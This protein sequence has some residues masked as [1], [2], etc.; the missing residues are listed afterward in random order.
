MNA[1]TETRS[2]DEMTVLRSR[3]LL[4]QIEVERFLDHPGCNIPQKAAAL[5]RLRWALDE[6][7]K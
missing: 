6:S 1:P 5:K 2:T 4:L 7:R 3:L